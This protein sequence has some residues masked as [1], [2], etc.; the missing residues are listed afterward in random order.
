MN[1]GSLDF[2]SVRTPNRTVLREAVVGSIEVSSLVS[3]DPIVFRVSVGAE[4]FYYEVDRRTEEVLRG[5]AHKRRP[6]ALAFD[7]RLDEDQEAK[8]WTVLSATVA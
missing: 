5:D 3:R 1:D 4:G 2:T 6:V 8:G 7:L